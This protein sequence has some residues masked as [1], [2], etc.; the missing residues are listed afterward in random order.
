MG[1]GKFVDLW[2]WN[3]LLYYTSTKLLNRG[4][5]IKITENIMRLVGIQIKIKYK[6]LVNKSK[7]RW[8]N[9][10]NSFSSFLFILEVKAI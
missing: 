10:N 7:R 5:E 3:W 6:I 4:K 2:K 8:L 9:Q 1:L